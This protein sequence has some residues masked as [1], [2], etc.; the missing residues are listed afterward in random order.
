MGA[1]ARR[2]GR[3]S[4][5]TD[6]SLT[7]EQIIHIAA[8]R[9]ELRSFLRHTEHVARRWQ[10]T[11]QRFLLLLVIKGA[12]AGDERLSLTE[13]ANSLHLSRNSVTE[14]CARAEDV[15]LVQREQSDEDLRVVYVRLTR[16]GERRLCGAL[17]EN[18]DYRGEVTEAFAELTASFRATSRG[19]R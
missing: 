8:F 18:E 2:A 12:P 3:T 7:K 1:A 13:I 5:A 14:L 11:P 9:R 10:L 15:G 19:R 16:E 17:L 4:R 6:A